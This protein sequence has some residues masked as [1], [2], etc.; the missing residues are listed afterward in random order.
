M[1]ENY[2][3]KLILWLLLLLLIFIGSFNKKLKFN[4]SVRIPSSLILVLTLLSFFMVYG[5][6]DFIFFDLDEFSKY[7]FKWQ[8]PSLTTTLTLITILS[9]YTIKW[10]RLYK[11][12][13]L[14][15]IEICLIYS[16]GV[17]PFIVLLYAPDSFPE[18]QLYLFGTF[19]VLVSIIHGFGMGI[20]LKNIPD[21]KYSSEQHRD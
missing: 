14:Q 15:D 13:K 12:T 17:M 21:L 5:Q 9:S 2:K 8:L 7:V 10:L 20:L 1:N 4:Y 19:T 11:K 16:V 3:I 18:Y 6:W